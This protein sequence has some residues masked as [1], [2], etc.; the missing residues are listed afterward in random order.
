MIQY[1]ILIQF[2]IFF[3]IKAIVLQG[4]GRW[5]KWADSLKDFD[6]IR[7][8]AE[9]SQIIVPT[10]NTIRYTA[11]MKLFLNHG[12]PCLF[13]GP[14]GTGKSIYISVSLAQKFPL[15]SIVFLVISPML[16]RLMLKK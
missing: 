7:P 3:S 15:K 5:V 10:I 11:L 2:S 9:F 8:D 14:T 16:S 12:K 6:A 1:S 13:V 4:N